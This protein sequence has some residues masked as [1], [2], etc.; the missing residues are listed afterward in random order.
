MIFNGWIN[1]LIEYLK[2]KDIFSI[3]SRFREDLSLLKPPPKTPQKEFTEFK[4]VRLPTS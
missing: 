1:W 3:F 4:E 2:K